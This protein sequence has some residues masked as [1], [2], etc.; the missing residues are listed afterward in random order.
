M[1]IKQIGHKIN[2]YFKPRPTTSGDK[3]A[4]S[5]VDAFVSGAFTGYMT[6]K[7]LKGAIGGGVGGYVG[8][9]VGQK[10][11]SVSKA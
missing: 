11:E 1:N 7:G 2:D 8:L 9:T 6:T 4:A 5:P 3:A 10:T